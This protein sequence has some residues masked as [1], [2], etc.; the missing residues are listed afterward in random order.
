MNL[1]IAQIDARLPPGD[2]PDSPGCALGIVHEGDWS[3]RYGYGRVWSTTFITP[4]TVFDIASIS[5]QFTAWCVLALAEEG[6]WASTTRSSVS[7]RRCRTASASRCATAASHQRA[8]RLPSA[9]GRS[10]V[11]LMPTFG[12]RMSTPHC[13]AEGFEL[14][15]GQRL[16]LLQHGLPA[17]G[18]VVQRVSGQTLRE[19]RPRAIFAPLGMAHH[20]HDDF[21]EIR[22]NRALGHALRSDGSLRLDLSFC[23]PSATAE[24]TP[25]SRIWRAG[26]PF[27]TQARSPAATP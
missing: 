21:T 23:D 7:V 15:A 14:C 20:F 12:V 27:F 1:P 5:K 6:N 22:P 16:H 8:A 19:V 26:M 13:P 24:S 10:P 25:R 4:A 11:C 3:T 18:E 17:L 9:S 2:R